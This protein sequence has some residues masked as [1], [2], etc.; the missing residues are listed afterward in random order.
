M[1]LIDSNI[2]M[3]LIG[4]SHPNKGLARQALEQAVAAGERLVTDAEVLQEILH[5]YV[6]IA[7]RAAVQPAFDA[8]LG[9]VDDVL[10]IERADVEEA[11]LLLLTSEELS[12][13]DAVHVAVMRRRGISRIM[14]FDRGFDRIPGVIRVSE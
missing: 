5:R 9:V 3:Y 4:E 8:L 14:S 7:R 13:R 12:A 10:A 2:P 1:I 6:A 11:K